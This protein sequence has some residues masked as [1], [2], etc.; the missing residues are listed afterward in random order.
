MKK[1]LIVIEFTGTGFFGLFSRPSGL[2]RDRRHSR[3]SPN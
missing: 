2:R 3:G 1:Y